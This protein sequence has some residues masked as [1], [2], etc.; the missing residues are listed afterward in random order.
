M[1]EQEQI[2]SDNYS[3]SRIQ[4]REL[5]QERGSYEVNS[6]WSLIVDIDGDGDTFRAGFQPIEGRFLVSDDKRHV[7]AAEAR[8][9][10][11]KSEQQGNYWPGDGRRHYCRWAALEMSFWR[12]RGGILYRSLWCRGGEDVRPQSSSIFCKLYIYTN[13]YLILNIKIISISKE[14]WIYILSCSQN[15]TFF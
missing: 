12:S 13:H 9:C 1:Q 5:K 10:E 7:G 11:Q 4:A 3:R 14:N 2:Y 15:V 8:R 6:R